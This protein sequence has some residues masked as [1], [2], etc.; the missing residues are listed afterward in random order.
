MNWNVL[1]R[2]AD[3]AKKLRK[4]WFFS[5]IDGIQKASYECVIIMDI[6]QEDLDSYLRQ[7]EERVLDTNVGK[8]LS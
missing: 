5:F 7:L 8:Q 3:S 1:S 4:Y 2:K 6:I